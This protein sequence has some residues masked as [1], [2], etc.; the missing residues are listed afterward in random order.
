[1][2]QRIYGSSICALDWPHK[3]VVTKWLRVWFYACTFTRGPHAKR[4]EMIHSR[5][6][7]TV[8]IHV[9][10]TWLHVCIHVARGGEL[11]GFLGRFMSFPTGG[12]FSSPSSP[13][14][15][16]Y[17]IF[18]VKNPPPPM[19]KKYVI[20]HVKKYVIFRKK[21]RNFS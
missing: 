19:L 13:M 7:M 4:V 2:L 21:V 15:K 1:M 5:V 6:E 20:F 17:V 10:V 16:K 12:S 3:C 9:M 8:Y 18:H 11:L 14:L